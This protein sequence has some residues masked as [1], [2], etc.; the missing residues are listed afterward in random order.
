MD[1]ILDWMCVLNGRV[2][3]ICL[4]FL[5]F[6]NFI[7]FIFWEDSLLLS[8]FLINYWKLKKYILLLLTMTMITIFLWINYTGSI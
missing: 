8:Y 5:Q 3:F 1:L 7:Y 6:I 2:L 4:D